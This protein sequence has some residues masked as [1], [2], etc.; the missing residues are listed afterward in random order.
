MDIPRQLGDLNGD[1]KI[2]NQPKIKINFKDNW[3][4]YDITDFE[5]IGYK[6]ARKI[7]APMSA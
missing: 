4:E 6:S 1:M 5:L 2:L 3:E 7:S